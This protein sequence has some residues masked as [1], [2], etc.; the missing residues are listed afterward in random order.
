M[1]GEAGERAVDNDGA[2]DGVI[3]VDESPCKSE[4]L[5]LSEGL[6]KARNPLTVEAEENL[7]CVEVDA[8]AKEDREPR[9]LDIACFEEDACIDVESMSESLH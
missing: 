8:E 7:E 2:V 3:N 6:L 1:A 5:R 4:K 9:L